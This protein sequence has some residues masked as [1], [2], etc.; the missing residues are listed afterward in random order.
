M[1]TE[2]IEN[3]IEHVDCT[4]QG[5]SSESDD[6]NHNNND[7]ADNI[8][9]NYRARLRLRPVIPPDYVYY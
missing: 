8:I 2:S 1:E 9:N 6:D 3:D 7:N 4:E 5:Y